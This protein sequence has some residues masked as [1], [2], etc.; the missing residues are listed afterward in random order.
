[1]KTERAVII[2]SGRVQG[3]GF[4]YT[5]RSLVMGFAVTGYVRNLENGGVEMVIEGECK[6]IQGFLQ[7]IEESHL[8]PF[9]RNHTLDWHSA[10]GEW[11]D[12][13]IKH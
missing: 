13:Y 6:E 5:C 11:K 12:F 3:I 8:K 2:F 7:A 10:T 9:I 4:R 1:M